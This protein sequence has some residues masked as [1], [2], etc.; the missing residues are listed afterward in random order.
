MDELQARQRPRISIVIPR[1]PA[2]RAGETLLAD[3]ARELGFRTDVEILIVDAEG[4]DPA[5]PEA[6]V[7][8]LAVR[9]PVRRLR[10]PA[11]RARQL[12]AGAAAA[13][14]E[15]LW[16]L[17]ADTRL[18][19]RTLPALERSLVADPDAFWFFRL[20]FADDGPRAVRW[21]ERGARLR[22]EG[23]G[24]PF[25]DQAF[26]LSRALFDRLGGYDETAAYGE[27]H[28]LVWAA[29]HRGVRLRCTGRPVITSARKYAERGWLRVTARHLGLTIRQAV[30]QWSRR[31]RDEEEA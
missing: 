26:A 18:P 22:S 31:R 3:L 27:D 7:S 1:A 9:V 4:S 8:E 23:L 28:L 5:G 11:G 29:R 25:G 20:R 30:A 24:L 12:N 6:P 21:N 15:F 2:E 14:G 13:Q 16:F 10:A 17:H 19:P